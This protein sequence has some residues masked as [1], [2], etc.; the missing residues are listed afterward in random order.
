MKNRDG[1]AKTA[2][3]AGHIGA[4]RWM[5]ERKRKRQEGSMREMLGSDLCFLHLGAI[6]ATLPVAHRDTEGM[7]M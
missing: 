1:A 2:T 5:V 6:R 7:K 4:G 3:Y